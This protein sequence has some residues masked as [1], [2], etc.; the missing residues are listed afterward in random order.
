MSS[1][2]WLFNCKQPL[3]NYQYLCTLSAATKVIETW[4]KFQEMQNVW[5]ATAG[6]CQVFSAFNGCACNKRQRRP[7]NDELCNWVAVA[8]NAKFMRCYG[9]M[10]S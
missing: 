1:P 10:L 8:V 5:T 9:M 2:Q 6:A 3:N 7:L 4:W